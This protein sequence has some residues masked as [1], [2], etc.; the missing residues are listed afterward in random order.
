MSQEWKSLDQALDLNISNEQKRSTERL[1][2]HLRN[3]KNVKA[4]MKKNGIPESFI[5]TH[6][7]RIR[8][9][10]AGI[11][12]CSGCKGLSEC[13]QKHKGYL[14]DL[15]YDGILMQV[16]TPCRYQKERN[17]QLAHQANY[18]SC[19]MSEAQLLVDFH[20]V[21]L[22]GETEDYQKVFMKAM[23]A[24]RDN[25]GLYLYG[26]MGTGKT[27]LACC[28]AN[29]HA[30]HHEK[31][32]FIHYPS[33]TARMV[34][35]IEGGE[36]KT[37][38]QRLMFAKFLVI[39]DIGAESVTE[40]N[41]DQILLPILNK[42]YEDGLCTWFTSNEDFRSLEDHFRYTSKGKEEGV[43]AKRIMERIRMLALAQPLTGKDRRILK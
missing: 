4:L 25:K 40:W 16:E 43:K 35:Q 41:R 42:R 19:D 27:Y 15:R 30:R 17:T 28:A 11:H 7:W 23:Q 9:W 13:R 5:E 1:Q 37:E 21:R 22:D 29:Y 6:P 20:S 8:D 34:S 26:D 39:D 36:Y 14:S 31:T 32:A 33:F 3:H 2:N 12:P 10:I 24:C 38:M 18:L